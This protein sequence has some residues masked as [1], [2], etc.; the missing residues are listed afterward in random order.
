[1]DEL[2]RTSQMYK[3]LIGHTK[4]LLKAIFELAITHKAF[5]DI[6]AGIASREQQKTASQAFSQFADAHRQIDKYAH[7]LLK[8]IKPVSQID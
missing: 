4:S 3:G 1:M 5:S 7:A 2:E 6:F 8:K